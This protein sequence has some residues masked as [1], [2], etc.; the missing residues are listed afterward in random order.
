[1]AKGHDSISSQTNP[2][3]PSTLVHLCR[4]VV[5]NHSLKHVSPSKRANTDCTLSLFTSSNW[6]SAVH[7]FGVLNDQLNEPEVDGGRGRH[8]HEEVLKHKK[9]IQSIYSSQPQRF[10]NFYHSSFSFVLFQTLPL[11]CF[12]INCL[13]LSGH[14]KDFFQVASMPFQDI[15]QV[16]S[17]YCAGKNLEKTQTKKRFVT[18]Q[19]GVLASDQR[20]GDRIANGSSFPSPTSF[21]SPTSFSASLLVLSFKRTFSL[22]G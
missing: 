13:V 2:I 17:R 21:V 15:V 7:F 6:N 14:F 10:H 8:G 20:H 18:A 3:P 4:V 12:P 9:K 16:F 1:M 5:S 22:E 11:L 19:G